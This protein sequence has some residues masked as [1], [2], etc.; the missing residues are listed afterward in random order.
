[1]N[2]PTSPLDHFQIRLPFIHYKIE[3]V[4]FIQGLILGVT[5]LAA[6]PYLEQ[7]LGL[8]YELAWSCVIIETFLYLLHSLL[9]DPVVP[10]WITPTL[11][12]TIVF[13]EGFPHGKRANTGYD[14]T[15]DAGRSGIYLYGCDQTGG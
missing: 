8:P 11:P 14:R 2:C 9:G 12:L 3:S 10:G 5:A 13:L 1:M 7:Y 15:A 6:V 4:E